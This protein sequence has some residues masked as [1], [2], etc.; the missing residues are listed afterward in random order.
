MRTLVLGLGNPLFFND[1][2][3]WTVARRLFQKIKGKD[4]F[5]KRTS[6]AGFS[7]LGLISGYTRVILVDSMAAREQDC[8]RCFKVEPPKKS[9]AASSRHHLGVFEVLRLARKMKLELPR[10]FRIYAI[11]VPPSDRMARRLN[12]RLNRQVTAIVA[13]ICQDL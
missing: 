9:A 7:L 5:L 11:G 1:R 8:G 3:G 13:E 4:V 2:L 10:D 12:P 6:L